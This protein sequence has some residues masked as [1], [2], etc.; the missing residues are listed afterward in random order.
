MSAPAA[1]AGNQDQLKRK[2]Y[3]AEQRR[4]FSSHQH[5]ASKN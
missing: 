4:T 2:S 3:Q 1:A 5:Y